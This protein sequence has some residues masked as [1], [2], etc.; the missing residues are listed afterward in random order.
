MTTELSERDSRL[1]ISP[2]T[3]ETHRA[4]LMHKLGLR[5]QADVI[6]YALKRGILPIDQKVK[7]DLSR[8]VRSTSRCAC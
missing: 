7:S 4:N 1:F 3:V 2:R 6:R 8:G 5:S